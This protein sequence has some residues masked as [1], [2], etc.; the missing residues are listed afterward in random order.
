MLIGANY[1]VLYAMTYTLTTY[2]C[3]RM[4]NMKREIT[5]R[6]AVK[7]ERELLEN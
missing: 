4:L 5:V 1:W 7:P 6:A 3:A 2:M